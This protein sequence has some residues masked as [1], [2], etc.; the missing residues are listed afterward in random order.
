MGSY[1]ETCA[2]TQLAIQEGDHVVFLVLEQQELFEDEVRGGVY[3]HDFW[4]PCVLPI[5]AQYDDFGR[6]RTKEAKPVLD[7]VIDHYKRELTERPGKGRGGKGI[8]RERVTLPLLLD[9]FSEGLVY[10]ER[11]GNRKSPNL[12]IMVRRGIW[13]SIVSKGLSHWSWPDQGTVSLAQIMDSVDLWFDTVL[14]AGHEEQF[15]LCYLNP[16][17]R[18]N[19][20]LE[21]KAMT[22]PTS[23]IGEQIKDNILRRMLKAMDTGS[24]DRDTFKVQIQRFVELQLVQNYFRD[25]RLSW[26]P[27]TGSSQRDDPMTALDYHMLCAREAMNVVRSQRECLDVTEAKEQTKEIQGYRKLLSM[28]KPKT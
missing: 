10:T 21:I 5:Y 3:P 19:P 16:R 20:W 15:K 23:G 13:D 26:A 2:L 4:A 12:P 17:E 18:V 11:G 25:V 14:N 6:I 24:F 9:W 8:L 27:T 1:N 7:A 28:R 22:M